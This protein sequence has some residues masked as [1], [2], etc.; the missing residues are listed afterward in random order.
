MSFE[1]KQNYSRLRSRLSGRE[2]VCAAARGYD[3][4]TSFGVAL[5]A[6]D[7]TNDARPPEPGGE[8]GT[9]RSTTSPY[10]LYTTDRKSVV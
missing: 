4:R 3:V 6:D 7:P 10:A 5:M 2:L 9:P 8:Y 1:V